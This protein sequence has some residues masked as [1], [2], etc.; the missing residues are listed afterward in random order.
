MAMFKRKRAA[1]PTRPRKKARY[2]RK[3]I[4][5]RGI[6]EPYLQMSRTFWKETWTPSTVATSNFWKYYTF[7]MA[8]LPSFSDMTNVFDRFKIN[9][10]KVTFR[11][12]YDGFAGND[13][14]DTTLP[15]VTNQGMCRLHI[16][17]DPASNVT[18]SGVYTSA[19]MNAFLE[20]G[21]VRSYSGSRPISIYFKPTVNVTTGGVAAGRRVR[22]GWLQSTAGTSIEHNG[23]HVYAQDVN[24]TGVFNQ[25][26]DVFVTYYMAFKG[27]RG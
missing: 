8:D 1:G 11:P 26:W 19:N 14:V 10:I 23:F 13:T 16:I 21:S 27:L 18:P 25:A 4:I 2:T 22:A 6:R 24:F 7:L 5:P 12:R 20:N 17:N 15:G 9:G 3:A